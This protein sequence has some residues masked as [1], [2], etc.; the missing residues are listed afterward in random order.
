MSPR[1]QTL[2]ERLLT[3]IA[4]NL[5]GQTI[6]S[7]QSPLLDQ[8]TLR[9]LQER[10]DWEKQIAR[11]T[12][13]Q[14]QYPDYYVHRN[15]VH[16][17]VSRNHNLK[18][19]SDI[20]DQK[21]ENLNR[22]DVDKNLNHETD[23]NTVV[24][25][26]TVVNCDINRN[27]HQFQDSYDYPGDCKNNSADRHS[28][29]Q[30][31]YQ[32]GYL[33]Q[34]SAIAYDS[35]MQFALPPN[36]HWVRQGLL[37]AIQGQ[38]RRI[39]DLGCGTGST[40]LLLQ[41]QFPQAEVVGLDLSPYMLAIANY[42]AQQVNAPIHWRHGNAETTGFADQTFDLI[43]ASLLF[44][45]MPPAIA[46][47]ILQEAHRLL[48]SGGEMVVLDGNPVVVRQTLWLANLLGE[49][50]VQDYAAGC[51]QHWLERAGFAIVSSED[52]W[53]CYQMSRGMKGVPIVEPPMVEP[54]WSEAIDP[55]ISWAMG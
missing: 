22:F 2:L 5:V 32:Q 42:K 52:L 41:K 6:T 11:L 17:N 26:D 38:P 28:P 55:A 34:E 19:N 20:K 4:Q 40:T 3:P 44:H 15:H 25:S 54:P 50:Y 36:E 21:D 35:L 51:L 43:T 45:E 48:K 14:V 49:P 16:E 18:V 9:Q 13:P 37:D 47:K 8:A 31:G 24:N 23:T 53:L 46:Q 7:P 12:N 29:H 10:I 39:L 1:P 30:Q 27:N 33:C